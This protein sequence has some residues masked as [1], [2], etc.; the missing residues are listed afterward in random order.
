MSNI[1]KQPIV[2]PE[3]VNVTLSGNNILVKGKLGELNLDF[4]SN[5][6]VVYEENKVK[7]TRPSDSKKYREYHGLYRAL[8]NNMVIGV[9]IGF[10]KE[11][12]LVGVGYT[13]EKKGDFLLVNAGYS[14]PVY[15]EIPEGIIIETP[16]NTTIIIKGISKQN[17]G[18]VAAKIRQIR[19]PEPYKGKGIKYADEYVRRKA[20]KTIGAAV[21]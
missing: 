15:F 18:D 14:H 19:K 4:N 11:L 1:G 2:I 21:G 7:V 20:G 10:S 5:M 17:V 13:T 16:K 9:N 8:I 6:K 3:G 12:H